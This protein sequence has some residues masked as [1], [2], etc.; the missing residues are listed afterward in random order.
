[1]GQKKAARLLIIVTI[2]FLLMGPLTVQAKPPRPLRLSSSKLNFHR[3]FYKGNGNT[4]ASTEQSIQITNATGTTITGLNVGIRGKDPSD[5]QLTKFCPVDLGAGEHCRLALTFTPTTK[6]RRK[7][8][9]L[10]GDATAPE[11]AIV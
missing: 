7:A 1:M 8:T 6:G 5:F 9:L 3:V 11:V 10:I 2:L 4:D